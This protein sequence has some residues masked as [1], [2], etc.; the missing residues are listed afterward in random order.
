MFSLTDPISLSSV[1][2][3]YS[4][5]ARFWLEFVQAH[6]RREAGSYPLFLVGNKLDLEDER[7][8]TAE[9][10]EALAAEFGAKYMETSAKTPEGVDELFMTMW[11]ELLGLGMGPKAA[12][13]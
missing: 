8:V 9:E 11:Q 4:G 12:L 7:Q 3:Y 5:S 13:T 2:C 6:S 10:A 1:C